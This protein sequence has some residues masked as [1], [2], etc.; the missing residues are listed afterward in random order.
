MKQPIITLASLLVASPAF[1]E[2]C[3]KERPAWSPQNG[4]INQFDDLVLFFIEPVGLTVLMLSAVAILLRRTWF[5]V[6]TIIVV[7]VVIAL[8]VSTW[9]EGDAITTFA[10]SEGCLV[11]P[12]MTSIALALIVIIL[13]KMP[14]RT[15]AK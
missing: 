15:S 2:V 4:P 10:Y 13:M 9:L 11:P 14:K 5:A 12:V 6:L 7:L 1:A 8:K 3:D